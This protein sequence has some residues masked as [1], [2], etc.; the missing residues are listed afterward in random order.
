MQKVSLFL[1]YCKIKLTHIGAYGTYKPFRWLPDCEKI[2][3]V[4]GIGLRVAN[5]DRMDKTKA[6][7][8]A[9]GVPDFR[10]RQ[11]IY[12]RMVNI[13]TGDGNGGITI[14][15]TRGVWR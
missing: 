11:S 14:E 7:G 12:T 10:Q 9:R 3:Y 13:I 1:K 5:P 15:N 8:A 4:A 6:H 2:A